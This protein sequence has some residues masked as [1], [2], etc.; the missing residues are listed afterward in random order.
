MSKEYS[1]AEVKKIWNKVKPTRLEDLQDS[2]MMKGAS[3]IYPEMDILKAEIRELRY[4]V[5]RLEIEREPKEIAVKKFSSEKIKEMVAN[6]LKEKS[7]AFPSDMADDLGLSI[8]DIMTALK[9]LQ[10]E[11]KVG[12]V[13]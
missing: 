4:K 8:L 13:K 11:K 5:E 7:E 3:S 9:T 6:Y 10:K 1:E 2:L 12:E